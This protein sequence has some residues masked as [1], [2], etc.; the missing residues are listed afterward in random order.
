[1]KL[2]FLDRCAAF[3]LLHLFLDRSKCGM[4]IVAIAQSSLFCSTSSIASLLWLFLF[5]RILELI[6]AIFVAGF[7]LF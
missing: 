5:I 6:L 4:R 1:M 2:P 3:L 7:Y